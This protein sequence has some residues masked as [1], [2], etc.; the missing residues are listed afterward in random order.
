V[1]DLVNRLHHGKSDR[2]GFDL[3]DKQAVYF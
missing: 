1:T 3:F 2:V